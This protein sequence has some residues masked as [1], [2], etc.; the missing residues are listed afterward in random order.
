MIIIRM[1]HIT[2]H[3]FLRNRIAF[4]IS[5]PAEQRI[6]KKMI[7]STIYNITNTLCVIIPTVYHLTGVKHVC[8]DLLQA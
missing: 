6:Y 5:F 3:C 4:F 7:F 1:M 8:Y 2:I